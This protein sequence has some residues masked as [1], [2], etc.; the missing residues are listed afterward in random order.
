[1]GGVRGGAA[2]S[3]MATALPQ[4]RPCSSRRRD[5]AAAAAVADAAAAAAFQIS[6]RQHEEEAVKLEEVQEVSS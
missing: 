4:P 3:C 6:D 2:R 1:M 5:R